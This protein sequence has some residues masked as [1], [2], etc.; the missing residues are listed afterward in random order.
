M[1]TPTFFALPSARRELLVAAAIAEFAERPYSDASL[2]RIAR[3]TGIAKGS[4]YQYFAD[5]LDLYR[6]L[7][8][9]EAP[10]QKRAFIGEAVG[11]TE[12]WSRLTHF[13]E[14][15]MAFLVEHPQLA[16]LTA[17]AADPAGSPEVR[18]LHAAV[19]AAAQQELT[20]LIAEGV[21]SGALPK[22]LDEARAAVWIAAVIG[23]GLTQQILRELGAELHEV[24]VSK[25]LK[26]RL[27]P[28]RRLE[29]A[30]QAVGFIRHGLSGRAPTKGKV[31]R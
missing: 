23:P 11:S 15:G 21:T 29:L 5:K 9:D 13:I 20:S 1:P 3:Q 27:G 31:S 8:T 16:R 6:W 4:L 26:K 28:K 17:Q 30:E 24:L 25:S 10:R 19:C 2:S 12:F 14:R 22:G 18:G 7:L